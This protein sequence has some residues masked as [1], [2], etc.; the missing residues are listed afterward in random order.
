MRKL[1][2]VRILLATFFLLAVTACFLDFTGTASSWFGWT[3]KLQLMPAALALS[4]VAV[5]ILDYI[6]GR[7]NTIIP[8]DYS[9]GI[10]LVGASSAD[11]RLEAR[12][13]I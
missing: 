11:I 3:V 8:G 1:R 5:V 12:L 9:L 7:S 2:A 10:I 4:L 6:I 13:K